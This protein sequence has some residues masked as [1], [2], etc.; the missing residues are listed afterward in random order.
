MVWLA[1]LLLAVFLVSVF[2]G[3]YPATIFMTPDRLIG[4]DLAQRLVLNL[5]L[6]RLLTAVFLGMSLSAAGAIFQMLF[7]NPLV[8]PGF[9]GVSQGAS[10]GAAFSIIFLSHSAWAVQSSA[11]FF[12]LAG[13]GL[14]YFIA[15]RVRFGGWILRL[16]LAGIAIS[17]LFS[18]LLGILKYIADPLSQLPE[19]T[20]WL[21]GSLSSVTWPQLLTILPGVIIG[22]VIA[23]RMRWRL[24]LLSLS[25]ETAF[26][27]GAAPGRERTLLLVVAV[28]VTSSVIS[29]AGMVMW[30]GLIIP[31]IARRLFGADSR[32]MLPA[33]MLIG[34][35]FT[36]LCDDLARTLFPGEIPLGVLTS[37]IGATVFMILMIYQKTPVRP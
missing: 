19:I 31:H 35:T 6:P 8:E 14:S 13:L 32:Y 24:N 27:L 26:S 29:V 9:L 17:A 33:S 10:F 37:L 7:G 18:S 25:D 36:V 30:V 2:V 5:R 3:R 16:V 34:A 23:Y 11:A 1:V 4:D 20:F 22:L 12:A 28:V 21:L 15:R